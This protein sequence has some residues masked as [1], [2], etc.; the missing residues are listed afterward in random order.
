[1]NRRHS[2]F[3]LSAVLSALAIFLATGPALAYLSPSNPAVLT[4]D[5]D[6]I[7]YMDPSY[8]GDFTATPDQNYQI[9]PG[10][11]PDY[12]TN[13]NWAYSPPL[14]KF[15]DKLAPLGCDQTNNL[16]QCVPVA[17]PDIVTYPGSDYY[18]IEIVQFHE[19][20]H[21]DLPAG[22]AATTMRGYHQINAGT[23]TSTCSDPVLGLPGACTEANNTDTSVANAGP[24][25]LGPII[26]TQKDRPVRIKFVNNLPTGEAG[27]LFVPVDTSIMGA[28]PFEIDYDP[29]T[30]EMTPL[31]T[32]DFTQNRA[33]LHL[34]GG[35]T[36][37][38]S[39]GTPHQWITPAGETTDYPTGVSTN[40]V[41]DMPDPGP[42]ASTYY[43]TNQ[44][45]SRLMFYHDHSWGITRLGVYVGGAA[46]YIIR[47]D[48]EQALIDA[49]ILPGVQSD[50]TT[51]SLGGEIPLIFED[52]TFVDPNTIAATDPTWKWGTAPVNDG[53]TMTPVLGDLWWPHVYMPAQNPY[54]FTGIAPMGRWAY[55]PYFW[56]ATNN[57][58]QPIPNP[59]YAA[60]CADTNANP[61]YCGCDPADDTTPG[62][63]GGFCQ[64]PYMPSSPNPSWGAEAFMD[65]PTI[66]GTAY[67]V[68]EVEPKAYRFR[69]L[70]AAHDRF[71]NLQMYKAVADPGHVDVTPPTPDLTG[72]TATTSPY[73]GAQTL[74]SLTEVP[75]LPATDVAT[76]S[77]GATRPDTW[78]ADGRPGGVPDWGMAG[79]PWIMIGSEGGFLPQP[80]EIPSHPIIWNADVTTFNAGNVNGGSL[81]VGPAERVDVVVDFSQYA[82][83][84]LIVYNDAPA[85]WPALDPHYDYYTGAP[86]NR[87]MGGTNTTPIGIGPNTRTVM[88]IKVAASGADPA[89]DVAALKAEFAPS[90]STTEI[91]VGVF[92]SSQD[93]I[94]AGQ[95]D[96]NPTGDPA[97]YEAFQHDGVPFDAY[98]NAYE[99]SA[100]T[101]KK[102]WP[103]W[104]IAQINDTQVSFYN[105]ESASIV[106]APL[107]KKA[108]QDEQGETF[109]EFGRMRAGLGLTVANPAAGQVNF[110][111]QTFSDPSTEILEEN[112]IQV[113]KI[114][115]NGVDTHPVHFHLFDVQ[116]LNRVGWD[117]FLRLPDPTEMGWKDTVRISPLE[118]T[119][120]AIRPITPALP[121]GIP[122][123]VRPL[124]PATT[125]DDPTHLSL[126]DPITG[127]AWLEPNLNRFM[128]FDWE[129]VWHCH[130][131]SH[132][133]NDMMRPMSF[134]FVEGLPPAPT[135]LTATVVGNG[136]IQLNWVDPTPVDFVTK[137]NFG[138]P[139]NEVRFLIE[140]FSAGTWEPLGTALANATTFTDTTAAAGTNY[141][142]RVYG[143]NATDIGQ[144]MGQLAPGAIS[145]TAP[146]TAPQVI[147]TTPLTG[148]NYL[149]SAIINMSASVAPSITSVEFFAGATSLGTDNS[150]PFTFAWAGA[151]A[152]SYDITAVGT[153]GVDTFISPAV[154]V[155]VV[156]PATGVTLIPNLASPQAAPATVTFTAQG[157]GS[158]G[159]QYEYQF[160]FK[161]PSTGNAWQ[162]VRN[163]STTATWTWNS[164]S[165]EAGWNYISVYTRALGSTSQVEAVKSISYKIISGS[166]AT[167]VTLTPDL[168]SPQTAPATVT[169]T[170]QGSGSSG[171]QYEYQFWLKGPSTGNAWQVVK[172][173]S[174]TATWTWNADSLAAGTNYISV[175]TRALGSTSQVE[176]VKSISYK[177]ISGSPATAVTLTPDLPSPQTAPATVTFTA[178]GSGSSGNQYEYQFWLKGPSTGNAW[179]VVRNYST[180]AT[181][182]W[183]AD[184]LAAGSNYISVYARALGSTSQAESLSFMLFT[185]NP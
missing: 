43:Y 112:G 22:T 116:V 48:T 162:V 16:G 138:N 32:G 84:E 141:S 92:Q 135:N 17:V 24:H 173:Y 63:L 104:G 183:N 36:P 117:G 150:A 169:F 148:S 79:P 114:T 88:K 180:T 68:L 64:P 128:N 9:G 182:T 57:H 113:W 168:P 47:D 158:S 123:S 30:K 19:Q 23:D 176:A 118:D 51:T 100:G 40:N 94:I 53:Q 107:E 164:D 81:I 147:L 130:I 33:L 140:R 110:V 99:P 56:P 37:W 115:H 181:W 58:F 90:T 119:I 144:P 69:I 21:S 163:Y 34:H 76:S 35:R 170:A 105:P 60:D 55:G 95:G 20:M 108:I 149:E 102:T 109:D 137:A 61:F 5:P 39:D 78:P 153:D 178:Q 27:K 125:L 49:A 122:E 15:V 156:T 159:N 177:I 89:Y 59:Y 82:G 62:S 167:A 14:R 152:G 38:I 86:D 184:S 133:E 70:N 74:A 83:Q 161:G 131:L 52:R 77:T 96:M 4:A 171:N 111:V 8:Q 154:T 127:Q 136:D 124:N 157:S 142:Y 93:T 98:V 145:N 185:I 46:G 6:Q 179:Q 165:T 73:V 120:V 80:V 44:Q 66:N 151:T 106:T 54:D 103:N 121:F 143:V 1:M 25:H 10:S 12:L 101:F 172:N 18:E 91:G 139:A 31:T 71:Y 146:I 166:P 85:P 50:G 126:V 72:F 129:Y 41:P 97:L 11:I 13:P 65:T 45:S 175:Y 3:W 132:E 134:Q 155:N 2:R 28:G 174:T 67:P 7:K 26:V 160:W 75:M 29:V 42:G 87:D